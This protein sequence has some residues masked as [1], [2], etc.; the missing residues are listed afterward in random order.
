[1]NVPGLERH[2]NGVRL[3]HRRQSYWGPE[4]HEQMVRI[5]VSACDC[6]LYGRVHVHSGD[7]VSKSNPITCLPTQHLRHAVST[8]EAYGQPTATMPE[9]QNANVAGVLTLDEARR[10][11]VNVARLPELL[12]PPLTERRENA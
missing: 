8:G 6:R 10:I 2:H 7:S 5:R 3:R 11:A 4:C 9:P 1:M 12:G